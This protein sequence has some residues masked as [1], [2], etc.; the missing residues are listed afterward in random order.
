MKKQ[1]KDT[2]SLGIGSMAGLS[3]MGS[4]S[5]PENKGVIS[6]TSASLGILG[7]GQ[8][9]KNT[10]TILG[11]MKDKKKKSSGSSVIDKI[12]KK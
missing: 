11:T 6:T 1:L 2:L 3:V 12:M 4:L 5:T 8:M 7:A 9:M 10:N